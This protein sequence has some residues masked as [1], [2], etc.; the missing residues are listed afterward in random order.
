M[1]SLYSTLLAALCMIATATF[2]ASCSDD[3]PGNAPTTQEET[4]NMIIGLWK[5]TTFFDKDNPVDGYYWEFT[6][7]SQLLRSFHVKPHAQGKYAQFQALFPR[8]WWEI[9]PYQFFSLGR[10]GIIQPV[11]SRIH[12]QKIQLLIPGRKVGRRTCGNPLR[13]GGWRHLCGCQ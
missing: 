4:K 8:L 7:D 9:H 2:T 12:G 3:D 5:S 11:D 1:K 10:R 6:A 13:L